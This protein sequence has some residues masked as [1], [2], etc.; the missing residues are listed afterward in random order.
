MMQ[1]KI[2]GI[3]ETRLEKLT[4]EI[5][6]YA[7]KINKIFNQLQLL[8]DETNKC[9]IT[10]EGNEFRKKFQNQLYNYQTINQNILSYVGDLVKVKEIYKN[11]AINI[12]DIIIDHTKK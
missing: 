4:L 1:D 3:N 5:I 7:D 9:F 12:A 6:D 10:S 8:L 2:I 11:S